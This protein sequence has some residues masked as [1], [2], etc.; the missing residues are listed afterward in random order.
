M[1]K[2]ATTYTTVVEAL[3]RRSVRYSLLRDRE[4]DSPVL[5]ELDLL[6]WPEDREKFI[7][8]IR[9]LG[10]S[11]RNDAPGKEVY[12]NFEHGRLFLLDVHYAFIQNGF[13][14]LEMNG[15]HE[16][17]HETPEG[18]KKLPPEDELL[19]LFF[20]NLVGKKHLQEK[21]LGMVNA[22]LAESLDENY[23]K[24]R[25]ESP[26]LWAIFQKFCANPEAFVSDKAM[27]KQAAA[28]IR[29]ILEKSGANQLSDVPKRQNK[30]KRG[31][32]FAFLGVDGAGKSTTVE[33]VQKL[34]EHAGKIKYEFV[35]MGPWGYVRSPILKKIYALKLFPSKENWAA[36]FWQKLSGKKVKTSL[37]KILQKWLSGLVKGWIYY[38]G[39]YFEMWYRYL[40]EVRPNV[41][42]GRI[43]LSDRYVYDLRYIYKKRPITQFKLFRWF[44]CKFFPAPDRV[45]FIWNSAEDIIARKPQLGA[46]EINL[47]QEYYRKTFVG[48]PVLEL[49]SDRP[50][51][52]LA[53]EIVEEIMRIYLS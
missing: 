29:E 30:P 51:E 20:H 47:F 46:E 37:P 53:R 1:Q 15:L 36:T 6:V 39:V 31:V 25:V 12:A 52:E 50:P 49:R 27:E 21:H 19:H 7:F 43:V 40:R 4:L 13:K 32:H 3:N 10:F 17:L 45:V 16:R 9:E 41:H 23:L 8:A 34:L 24:N 26:E 44:V 14:Y 22:C 11:L 38:A 42:K 33:H 48:K 18:F 5:D 2:T 35:Y 28:Q